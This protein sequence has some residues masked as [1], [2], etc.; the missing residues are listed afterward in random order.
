MIGAGEKRGG[1]LFCFREMSSTRAFKTTT[2]LSFDLW[3]KRSGHPSLEVL[4]LLPQGEC[5]LTAAYL[6]NRTPSPIL[7]RKTP[8]TV[9]H[10]IEPPYNHL[11]TFGCLCYAHTKTVDKFASRSRKC[12][13]IGYPCGQK[14]PIVPSV[15]DNEYNETRLHEEPLSQD[16]G[17]ELV[18]EE[19]TVHDN[20]TVRD[21][22]TL[23]SPQ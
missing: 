8:Y 13:F 9:L 3:H 5:I 19:T 6:I 12:V 16:R 10:N 7:K 23:S 17:N 1:G 15:N 18:N 11:R 22:G 14:E 20:Q 21:D 2:T 4:K